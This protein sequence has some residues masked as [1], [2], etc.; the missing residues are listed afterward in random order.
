MHA[1]IYVRTHFRFFFVSKGVVQSSDQQ[2][3]YHPTRTRRAKREKMTG[4][5]ICAHK[6]SHTSISYAW[7]MMGTLCV[8]RDVGLTDRAATPL[9]AGDEYIY[10]IHTIYSIGR[11]RGH[12]HNTTF[13]SC[14]LHS[15]LMARARVMMAEELYASQMLCPSSSSSTIFI[16][17]GW[18]N[19]RKKR[20]RF[21][22][23]CMC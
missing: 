12:G 4:F 17:G 10:T 5:S 20:G 16:D 18:W 15:S 8:W 9:A 13:L 1:H 11:E 2:P 23:V 3:A 22:D 14:L 21:G 6:N 7:R 19:Q